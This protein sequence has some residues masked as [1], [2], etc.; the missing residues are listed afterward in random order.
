MTRGGTNLGNDQQFAELLHSVRTSE[1]WLDNVKLKQIVS[2]GAGMVPHL[3]DILK[4]SLSNHPQNQPTNTQ[5][6]SYAILHTLFLLAHLQS[7]KSLPVILEFLSRRPDFLDCYLHDSLLDEIWEVV[8]CLGAN[9]IADLETFILNRQNNT[10]SRLAIATAL[11]Q[12]ALHYPNL[13]GRIVLSFTRLLDQ[14]KDD[15]DF[16]GLVISEL[17]DLKSA[18]LRPHMLAALEKNIV[19]SG[20]ITTEDVSRNYKTKQVRKLTPI[21]LFKRHKLY[22]HFANVV[23]VQT[24]QKSQRRTEK[25]F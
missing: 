23:Q 9:H 12:L 16:L 11:V 10:L 1:Q 15:P 13:K 4:Q 21:D 5:P 18:T 2:Y 20:I 24:S 6:Q 17:L 8:F 19:W 22:T 3:E 14:K 25:S 7:E